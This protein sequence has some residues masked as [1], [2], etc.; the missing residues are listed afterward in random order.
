MLHIK[1]KIKSLTYILFKHTF[2]KKIFKKVS[3]KA[4]I[5]KPLQIDGPKNITL[6]KYCVI[7]AQTWLAALAHG[8]TKNPTLT[9]NEGC[10]IGHFNH[11][12]CTGTITFEKNV[13]TADK[14]YI[15]DNLHEYENIEIPI[16][17]Q[18]IKHLKAMIIGEG[19]W[20]GENACIIGAN[21]GKGSVIGANSVVTKDIPDFCVAVGAPAKI[22]KQYNHTT[23]QWQK[24][25]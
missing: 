24:T 21:I 6:E 9:F 12:Y 5:Y 11:I 14:V 13:L 3:I 18:P 17:K 22:I 2:Y 15:S 8:N 1:N 19:A 25:Y 4:R 7:S 10:K 16:C 20:I 23:K